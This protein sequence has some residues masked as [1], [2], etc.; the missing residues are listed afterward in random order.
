M[1]TKVKKHCSL[2]FVLLLMGCGNGGSG[3]GRASGGERSQTSAVRVNELVQSLSAKIVWEPSELALLIADV[4][5]D[6]SPEI[7]RELD[8]KFTI[9]C[10][11]ACFV[12][13]RK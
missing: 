7:L 12:E 13:K 1:N 3:Q 11:E 5:E 10:G 9:V 2:V 8:K 6:Q 4:A